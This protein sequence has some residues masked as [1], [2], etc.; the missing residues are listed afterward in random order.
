MLAVV[1]PQQIDLSPGALVRLPG[2]WA[3]Y[4]TLAAR[5]SDRALPRIKY[6]SGEIFLMSPL[7]RHGRDANGLA[8]VAKELLEHQLLDYVAFTPITL[9]LP[10]VSGIEPDYCF[11]IE[12]CA[13]IAGK[14]R[15]A[16][17]IDPPPDLVI[18][19]D[20]T[21]Y[22]DVED[23]LAYGVPEVWLWKQQLE[24][25]SLI[26]GEYYRQSESRYF[27]G[28]DLEQLVMEYLQ[29]C[30]AQSTSAAI[31]NLRQQLD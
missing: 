21:S 20:V 2:D 30:R 15:I 19:V 10:E 1:S 13:A 8:D 28:I 5:L 27:P 26:N 4:Q 23:Y 25:Y 6:R 31:R 17:E 3:D 7:P 9:S 11:Y 12:H 14:D 16:W 22:T 24:S 18:E 29:I